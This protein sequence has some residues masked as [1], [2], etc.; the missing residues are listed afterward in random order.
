M[1]AMLLLLKATVLLSAT[2]LAARVWRRAPAVTRHRLW[3]LAFAAGLAL[4]LLASALP[5]LY[6]PVPAGWAARQSPPETTDESRRVFTQSDASPL[7][8]RADTS[9]RADVENTPATA[10]AGTPMVVTW[11]NV[12]TLLL[13]AWLIGT[14]IA[15]SALVVSLLAV[16]RL[17]RTS[18]DV[19]DPAWRNAADAL[20]A[21]LG[22]R[23]PARLI[24]SA[25]VSTP[26][27]GGVWRPVI[28]LP[29]SAREWSTLRRTR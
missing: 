23:R 5:V 9:V 24:V 8:V 4:P 1:E 11:S 17:A 28:F 12:R 13:A 15:A 7:K 29:A 18:D 3:S 20:G 25:A 26:M 16:R 27:A 6:V 19:G 10:R 22:L 2:L 14:T 21:R